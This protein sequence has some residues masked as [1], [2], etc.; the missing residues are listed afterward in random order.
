M[1][2]C[3]VISWFLAAAAAVFTFSCLSVCFANEAA[4]FGIGLPGS[5][6]HVNDTVT[7]TISC[8]AQS[9][10]DIMSTLIELEIDPARFEILSADVGDAF[11]DGSVQLSL[12]ETT[13]RF[14]YLSKDLETDILHKG[15]T[16]GT[17]T[18]KAR[19]AFHDALFLSSEV[20]VAG[21]I[22]N[23]SVDIPATIENPTLTVR[24]ADGTLPAEDSSGTSSGTSSGVSSD[25]SSSAALI[26]PTNEG[27]Q[28]KY[29][30]TVG[31]DGRPVMQSS[32]SDSSSSSSAVPPTLITPQ[33]AAQQKE[34]KAG[35]GSGQAREN[36]V[37][38]AGIVVCLAIVAAILGIWLIRKC[39]KRP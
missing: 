13:I 35:A 14:L 18:L 34:E 2:R 4:S 27:V 15:D 30:Q 32:E 6:C 38:A 7:C 20:Q 3:K 26:G 12:T 16:I 37:Q 24:N 17:V 8:T 29:T 23:Q 9:D 39:R 5:E 21:M 1:K 36:F 10:T 31:P 19:E 33:E 28:P 22:E 11:K 25:A